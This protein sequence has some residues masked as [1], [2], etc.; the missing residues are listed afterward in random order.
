MLF[1]S[2]N[3]NAGT[4]FAIDDAENDNLTMDLQQCI[5]SIDANADSLQTSL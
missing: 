5:S 2:I 3:L 1:S 4:T